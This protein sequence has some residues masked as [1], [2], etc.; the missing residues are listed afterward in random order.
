MTTL[1]KRFTNILLFTQNNLVAVGFYAGAD[2]CRRL[3]NALSKGIRDN[4]FNPDVRVA[5][6]PAN[7][8][9]MVAVELDRCTHAPYCQY[10][11]LQF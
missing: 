9:Y 4:S 10:T 6:N 1:L 3:Y 7:C 5:E 8:N 2:A 11:L